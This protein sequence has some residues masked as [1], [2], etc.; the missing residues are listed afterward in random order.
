LKELTLSQGFGDIDYLHTLLLNKNTNVIKFTFNILKSNLSDEEFKE[1]L[2]LRSKL[3]R[4]LFHTAAV[5][6]RNIIVH[7]FLW[8]FFQDSFKSEQEFLE[9]I[10]QKDSYGLNVLHFVAM[11]ST[12]EIF[13][14]I[15]KTL[16]ES[17]I[18]SKIKSLFSN[19]NNCGEN[20]L[21]SALSGNKSLKLHQILWKIVKKYFESSEIVQ[22]F[23]NHCDNDGDNILHQAVFWNTKEIANF[24]WNQIMNFL[25]TKE[26]LIEYLKQKGHKSKN[27]IRLS[28]GNVSNCT[29]IRVWVKNLM[30]YYNINF[31]E[32]Y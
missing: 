20:I 18:K 14:F 27:L 11:V 30:I 19:L 23:I 26:E 9:I 6:S 32:D 13:D 25:L 15:I 10:M 8:K 16:E 4:N 22:K 2:K 21:H 3:G 5:S 24:T 7:E 28:K 1:I 29:K 17:S 12:A 31:D